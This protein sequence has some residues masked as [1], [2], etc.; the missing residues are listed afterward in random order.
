LR[1]ITKSKT[2][3]QVQTQS[4]HILIETVKKLFPEGFN[5]ATGTFNDPVLKMLGLFEGADII[6][7]LSKRIALAKKEGKKE[8]ET[9]LSAL[10]QTLMKHGAHE[11]GLQFFI[12]SQLRRFI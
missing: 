6:D 10:Y 8:E 2:L 7:P 11:S 12:Q 4:L 9:I 3:A 1:S 5:G